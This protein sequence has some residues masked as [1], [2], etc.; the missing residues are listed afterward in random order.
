MHAG[1][2]HTQTAE[3]IQRLLLAQINQFTF[4]LRADDDCFRGEMVAR[5][6]LNRRDVFA[7]A[8]R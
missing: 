4:Q 5:V 8:E 3:V 1:V 7:L 6:L 2:F